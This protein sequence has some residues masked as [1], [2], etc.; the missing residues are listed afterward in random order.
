MQFTGI[1]GAKHGLTR[2]RPAFI[3]DP[4]LPVAEDPVFITLSGVLETTSLM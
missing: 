3:S 1:P 2:C 4:T